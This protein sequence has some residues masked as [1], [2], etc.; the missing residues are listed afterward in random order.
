M[1]FFDGD[2]SRAGVREAYESWSRFLT[3]DG[4]IAVH[5]SAP[6]NHRPDHDGQRLLVEEEIR[7]PHYADIRLVYSTTFARKTGL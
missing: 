7:P 1:I 6:D 2:Q 4:I 5:N 3:P